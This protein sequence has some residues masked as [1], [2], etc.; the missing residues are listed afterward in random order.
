M[1]YYKIGDQ[2]FLIKDYK[3]VKGIVIN[4][5]LSDYASLSPVNKHHAANS[6]NYTIGFD[7]NL[8]K[9]QVINLSDDKIV[10]NTSRVFY[11]ITELLESLKL[12][13]EKEEL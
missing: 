3:I 13:A 2:V 7:K 8:H 11:S 4:I 10:T 6:I 1:N 12:Q 5:S 9:T